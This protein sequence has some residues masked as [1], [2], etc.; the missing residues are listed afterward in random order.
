MH[1]TIETL[2]REKSFHL[3]SPDE[4]ALVLREMPA[5]EY[6]RLHRLL[7]AV[8]TLDTDLHPSAHLRSR[9]LAQLP[10]RPIWWNKPIP[11]W[12]AAAALMLGL[13]A[14]WLFQEKPAAPVP[15]ERVVVKT[16]TIYQ[17]RVVWKDRIVYRRKAAYPEAMVSIAQPMQVDSA[18][19]AKV[20]RSMADEPELAKF[21]VRT[22][23]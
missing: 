2:A 19:P 14:I 3:L 8:S 10:E 7:Q 18:I 23:R 4:Q 15:V 16:D 13:G 6:D 5:D 9:V 12:Q 11:V 20:G 22:D 1:Q 17:D 21:F